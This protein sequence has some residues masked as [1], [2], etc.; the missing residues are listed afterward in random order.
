MHGSAAWTVH[1]VVADTVTCMQNRP[2]P[3][4]RSADKS[5]ARPGRKQAYVS[6]RMA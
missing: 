1:F 6:V 4:Y 5:L 3:L 2:S